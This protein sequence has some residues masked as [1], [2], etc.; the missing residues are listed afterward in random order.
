MRV[1]VLGGGEFYPSVPAGEW[2]E[3]T[4]AGLYPDEVEADG[5]PSGDVARSWAEGRTGVEVGP[6]SDQKP[7]VTL[8][9]PGG[10]APGD[11]RALVYQS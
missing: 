10:S 8:V 9:M 6:V 7:D 5:S 11:A 1:R 4:L 2:L 3:E